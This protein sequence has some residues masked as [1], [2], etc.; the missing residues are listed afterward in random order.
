VKN[1]PKFSNL[2]YV[3]GVKERQDKPLSTCTAWGP[4][5]F[6]H[7]EHRIHGMLKCATAAAVVAAAGAMWLKKSRLRSLSGIK[8]PGQTFAPFQQWF[9]VSYLVSRTWTTTCRFLATWRGILHRFKCHGG[10][11]I[12]VPVWFL[13]RW[14]GAEHCRSHSSEAGKSHDSLRGL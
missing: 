2:A 11:R 9:P 1:H 12:E 6:N 3:R 4:G 5:Q 8:P 7:T 14:S 10:A 13:V